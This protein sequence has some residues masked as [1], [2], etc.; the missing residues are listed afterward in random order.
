MPVASALTEAYCDERGVWTPCILNF[1]STCHPILPISE[2]ILPIRDTPPYFT[3][4]RQGS[5]VSFASGEL[6]SL[7]VSI[8]LGHYMCFFNFFVKDDERI[9]A[10]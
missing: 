4:R 3:R 10:I 8:N 7:T 2:L 5:Q 6:F 9:G 1:L